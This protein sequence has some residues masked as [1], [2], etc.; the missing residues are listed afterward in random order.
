MR[1]YLFR[2][3]R[4]SKSSR[5]ICRAQT[6]GT[7]ADKCFSIGL[8][9]NC[10]CF[11]VEWGDVRKHCVYLEYGRLHLLALSL[12]IVFVWVWHQHCHCTC[13][14]K[15]LRW[16]SGTVA[17]YFYGLTPIVVITGSCEFSKVTRRGADK[18]TTRG[19]PNSSFQT[20]QP[21]RNSSVN[22]SAKEK[23]E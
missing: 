15:V 14:L 7:V 3:W 1:L 13:W 10:L 2:L 18:H 4:R 11:C 22:Y 16:L 9:L 20:I 17:R 23:Y 21:N 5:N 19:L 6:S 12:G 8:V